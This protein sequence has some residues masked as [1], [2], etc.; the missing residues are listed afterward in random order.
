[1]Y[2]F[3]AELRKDKAQR[4]SGSVTPGQ[5]P[6]YNAAVVRS[7]GDAEPRHSV[8]T[9]VAPLPP[10]VAPAPV[11]IINPARQPFVP[12]P[13]SNAQP[14]EQLPGPSN[15][16]RAS[17]PT[18]AQQPPP[19]PSYHE[20]SHQA[21]P[22]LVADSAYMS[23]NSDAMM[24]ERDDLMNK[25]L[26]EEDELIQCHRRQIEDTMDIV[27]SEMNLLAEVDQ[28]GSAIDTYVDKLGRT[29]RS[30]AASIQQ[31]QAK[32]DSFKAKLRQ[33][34]ILNRTMGQQRSAQ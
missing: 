30:K 5:N 4:S 9:Y 2:R 8:P 20:V 11:P 12:R 19:Q 16:G 32:L 26:E 15:A 1:M 3:C 7:A 6:S 18:F 10:P 22:T 23:E 17:P 13:I 21:V 29:L 34:E 27:R 33:E 14:Q 28:P 31:L 24:L 25:I